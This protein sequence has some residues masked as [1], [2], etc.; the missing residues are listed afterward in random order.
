[1]VDSGSKRT[2]R[3]DPPR[4]KRAE[5]NDKDMDWL[6]RF[7]ETKKRKENIQ[8]QYKMLS[9]QQLH[10]EVHEE[11]GRDDS[12]VNN[13][14]GS[15][16]DKEDTPAPPIKRGAK[17]GSTATASAKATVKTNAQANAHKGAAANKLLPSS[18]NA[19]VNEA[20][21]KS[22]LV[23][24][25]AMRNRRAN[26]FNFL[27]KELRMVWENGNMRLT[28]APT[29]QA[30]ESTVGG[31]TSNEELQ[32][33]G[34]VQADN[35]SNAKGTK[36]RKGPL[37]KG[38]TRLHIRSES[39]ASSVSTALL[40]RSSSPGL[41]NPSSLSTTLSRI[42]PRQ[43]LLSS[44]NRNNTPVIVNSHRPAPFKKHIPTLSIMATTNRLRDAPPARPRLAHSDLVTA[45][46]WDVD[47]DDKKAE[48][49]QI[50]QDSTKKKGKSKSSDYQGLVWEILEATLDK[51][52]A[53]LLTEGFFIEPKQLDEL[54]ARTWR[55]CASRVVDDPTLNCYSISINKLRA[56]KYCITSWQGKLKDAIKPKIPGEYGLTR[57]PAQGKTKIEKLL[58]HGFHTQPGAKPRTGYY[59]HPF[60][61]TACDV[62]VFTKQKGKPPIGT[63]FSKMFVK[64]PLPTIAL[65]CAIIHFLLETYHSNEEEHD[66]TIVREMLEEYYKDHLDNLL[67][68]AKVDPDAIDCIQTGMYQRGIKQA[69]IKPAM[70][71]KSKAKANSRRLSIKDIVCLEPGPLMDCKGEADSKS[72]L[73]SW[74]GSK[75][76]RK[77]N[78]EE[79]EEQEGSKN[80]EGS[81]AAGASTD[82]DPDVNANAD[83][84]AKGEGKQESG[85]ALDVIKVGPNNGWTAGGEENGRAGRKRKDRNGKGAER[86]P[87]IG[88]ASS[89]AGEGEEVDKG[90]GEPASRGAKKTIATPRTPRIF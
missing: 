43:P 3:M 7:R 52:F 2:L 56:I 21:L 27:L 49:K 75:K 86:A 81:A 60:L 58:N 69:P 28:L 79:Q 71:A 74:G 76:R 26:H 38:G 90:E 83:I 42:L 59:K 14:S 80:E 65:L 64:M 34:T 31:L 47:S 32:D 63:K 85:K 72:E 53:I 20:T 48:L 16:L 68:L 1:M 57:A 40:V 70:I 67:T 55:F 15:D 73:N 22:Q 35:P 33:L 30:A 82:T 39:W 13:K 8:E 50:E 44:A 9:Q 37:Y 17:V 78:W 62:T 5:Q 84:N 41:L 19:T 4:A 18:G 45:I 54:I 10:E 61:Q 29:V 77:D 12:A 88:K 51:V 46:D 24:N 87:V 36:T 66:D 25:I 89:K 6:R 11:D 23:A